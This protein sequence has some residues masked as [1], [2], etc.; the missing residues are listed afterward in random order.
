M[1]NP[2]IG[3]L[4]LSTVFQAQSWYNSLQVNYAKKISHGLQ[5]EVSFTWQ[6]SFDTSSGSFAGDN[7]S[8]NPTAA[9]PWWDLSITKGLSDFNIT[10]ILSINWLYQVPT[11]KAFAGPAG[12]ATRGWSVGGLLSLSDGVPMWPLMGLSSDPLGQNNA[13]PMD[14]PDLAP[15]CTV[16]NVVQHNTFNYLNPACFIYPQAPSAAYAAANCDQTPNFGKNGAE[17]SL[18]SFGLPALTCTNLLG[19]LPRNAIIGPGLFDVDM[20]F[21]KDNHIAKFGE[22]FNIQFR[23]EFFNIFNR[24]NFAPPTDNLITFD[25]LPGDQPSFGQLDQA[26][27]IP[28]RQIQ[29]ALK[30]VF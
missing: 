3:G 2:Y 6:K 17:G 29:F 15:G 23:A 7:Y 12:W 1:V 8:S 5:A 26:P 22:T 4:L 20:S 16:K 27:Q 10:R 9:T 30:I 13:E 21:I 11:P 14:I 18:A 19:N 24:T 28:M 25:P